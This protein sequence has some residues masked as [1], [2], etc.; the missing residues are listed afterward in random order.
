[1]RREAT[2]VFG[3]PKLRS[4]RSLF[5]LGLV[6]GMACGAGTALAQGEAAS[7]RLE[8]RR[9]ERADELVAASLPPEFVARLA[10]ADKAGKLKELAAEALSLGVGEDPPA[11]QPGMLGRYRREG[12]TLVF[13]P[14][15]RLQPGT[16][17]RARLAI[18]GGEP[19]EQRFAIPQAD[20]PPTRV[21][22]VYP[23]AAVLPE[24]QLKFYLHFSAPM[25]QGVAFRHLRLLDGQGKPDE[26]PFV[27]V[28]RELWDRSGTRLTLLLDPGRIKHGLKPREEQGPILHEGDEHTLVID[29]AWPDAL[30]RPLASVHEKRFRVAAPDAEMPAVARWKLTPPQAGER[31]QLVVDFDEPFD[32]A[33]LLDMLAVRGPDGALVE[34]MPQV[35]NQERRWSF[36]P[37]APWAAGDYRLE[38]TAT[39]EDLAGNSLA[40]PFEVDLFEKI[41]GAKAR[42]EIFEL[43]FEVRAAK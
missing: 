16:T 10:A 30:G 20:A 33:L 40:K 32:H 21:A 3:T 31:G 5:R 2:R 26:L 41:D 22:A 4:M 34:G 37:T 17:Y 1:M 38:A 42:P 19:L 25:R 11:D 29:P 28:G 43:P 13:T 12:A 9:G 39:L 36:T 27:D 35:T 14:R 8:L 6:L 24:N 23:S 15:L 7:P 18:A